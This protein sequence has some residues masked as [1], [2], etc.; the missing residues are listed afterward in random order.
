MRRNQAALRKE[1]SRSDPWKYDVGMKCE[2]RVET[3][4]QKWNN[5]CRTQNEIQDRSCKGMAWSVNEASVHMNL[6]D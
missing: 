3:K 5:V 1:T 6:G 2:N 4:Q